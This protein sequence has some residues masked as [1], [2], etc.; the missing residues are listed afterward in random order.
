MRQ[1]EEGKQANRV[2]IGKIKKQKE[3]QCLNLSRLLST[4]FLDAL[5]DPCP[6]PCV[7]SSAVSPLTKLTLS[8]GDLLLL[9]LTWADSCAY[10]GIKRHNRS[11]LSN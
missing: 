2:N 4:P 6:W 10:L 7:C 1:R 3:S 8:H 9:L 5:I 11:S